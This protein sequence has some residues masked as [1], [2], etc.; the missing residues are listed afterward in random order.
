MLLFNLHFIK[1]LKHRDSDLR[2]FILKYEITKSR[3][4]IPKRLTAEIYSKK[5]LLSYRNK[6]NYQLKKHQKHK[7][8]KI[9]KSRLN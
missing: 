7:K 5:E 9:Y 4:F 1:T 3:Q 2:K 6:K 8:T